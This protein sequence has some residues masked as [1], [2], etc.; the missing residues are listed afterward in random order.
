MTNDS[1]LGKLPASDEAC[2]IA[3]A[4]PE[5]LR[6]FTP[7]QQLGDVGATAD[8]PP[9][10]LDRIEH[11]LEDPLVLLRRPPIAT[12][13]SVHVSCHCRTVGRLLR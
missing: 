7:V 9:Q 12:S 5:D 2:H 10:S 13:V 3:F 6:H 4:R 11:L 8:V 1:S